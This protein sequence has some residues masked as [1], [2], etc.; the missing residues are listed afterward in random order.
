MKNC[1]SK[2]KHPDFTAGD[3]V[4]R[5]ER[6]TNLPTFKQQIWKNGQGF[7][8]IFLAPFWPFWSSWPWWAPPWRLTGFS[9]AKMNL[10]RKSLRQK[11]KK[12][13]ETEIYIPLL[14]QRYPNCSSTSSTSPATR[15]PRDCS[16]RLRGGRPFSTGSDSGF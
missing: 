14:Y 1:R 4:F 6:S 16:T 8:V 10:A 5:F 9:S 7:F 12:S 15:T 11:E 2:D 13:D 3:I